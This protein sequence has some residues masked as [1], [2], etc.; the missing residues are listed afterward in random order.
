MNAADVRPGQHTEFQ[1]SYNCIVKLSLK[2]TY[3]FSGY[4]LPVII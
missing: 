4:M 2:P 1:V 3:S